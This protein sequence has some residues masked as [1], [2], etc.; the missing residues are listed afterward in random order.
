MYLLI[1]IDTRLFH[2]NICDLK[3]KVNYI[4]ST[5]YFI[6]LKIYNFLRIEYQ[7]LFY[8]SLGLIH[9]FSVK[10]LVTRYDIN[11]TIKLVSTK[12]QKTKQNLIKDRPE[13]IQIVRKCAKYITS[14]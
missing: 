4:K 13:T 5:Q 7:L 1:R 9:L 3:F 12:K 11:T 6:V 8:S 10:R 2:I 14:Y